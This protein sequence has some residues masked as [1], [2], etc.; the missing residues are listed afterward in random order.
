MIEIVKDQV[1]I[2]HLTCNKMKP[3]P[4]CS[5][6]KLPFVYVAIW[7]RCLDVLKNEV[8]ISEIMSNMSI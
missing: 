1:F 6:S 2:I 5:T 8:I 3:V 4:P 7:Q